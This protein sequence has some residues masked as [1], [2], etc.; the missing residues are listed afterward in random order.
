VLLF[1]WVAFLTAVFFVWVLFQRKYGEDTAAFATAFLFVFGYL[2]LGDITLNDMVHDVEIWHTETIRTEHCDMTQITSDCT[3][4][5]TK[6]TDNSTIAKLV[7][8]LQQTDLRL[9]VLA[10]ISVIFW[11]LAFYGAFQS[12]VWLFRRMGW[13]K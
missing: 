8:A 9:G 2:V 10:V 1:T 7:S 6:Q 5:I 4:T 11:G 3:E 12:A 13:L